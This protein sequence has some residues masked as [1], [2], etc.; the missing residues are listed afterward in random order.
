MKTIAFILLLFACSAVR[1]EDK[2]TKMPADDWDLRLLTGIVPGFHTDNASLS[3]AMQQ[4][5]EQCF[6]KGQGTLPY[7]LPQGV[8]EKDLPKISLDVKDIPGFELLVYISELSGCTFRFLNGQINFE[9][10]TQIDD[11]GGMM[12]SEVFSVTIEGAQKIGLKNKMDQKEVC[13][14]LGNYGVDFPEYASALWNPKTMQL[15]IRNHRG[16]NNVV[17]G[18]VHLA[19]K[20]FEFVRTP[21]KKDAHKKQE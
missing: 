21:A 9:P 14:L 1:A 20:G 17:A 18:L 15:A 11:T 12:R 2:P 3:E 7:W 8:Q 16:Q 6:G 13:H 4:L 19:N 5:G 10:I